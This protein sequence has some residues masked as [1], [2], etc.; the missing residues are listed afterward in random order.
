[1]EKQDLIDRSPVRFLEKATNGSLQEGS[2]IITSKRLGKNFGPQE[3][4][5]CTFSR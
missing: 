1:M 3:W 2:Y 4:S 5:R